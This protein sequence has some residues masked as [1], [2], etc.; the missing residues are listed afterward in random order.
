MQPFQGQRNEE[1]GLTF[2]SE[3]KTL[4]VVWEEF[5]YMKEKAILLARFL[6]FFLLP[7]P[8]SRIRNWEG[9]L[10]Q[11]KRF[12]LVVVFPILI[13]SNRQGQL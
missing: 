4:S 6:S 8:P 11:K 3:S 1:E 7:F 10:R 13:R 2:V 9:S 5:L 12:R